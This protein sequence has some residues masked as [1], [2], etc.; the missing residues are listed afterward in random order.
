MATEQEALAYMDE[1][2]ESLK[3]DIIDYQDQGENWEV[4]RDQSEILSAGTL[5]ENSPLRSP[6]AGGGN[7]SDVEEF[8]L[9]EGLYELEKDFELQV[10]VP[11]LDEALGRLRENLASSV[12]EWKDDLDMVTAG[13]SDSL[14]TLDQQDIKYRMVNGNAVYST[15]DSFIE[16]MAHQYAEDYMARWLETNSSY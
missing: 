6:I 9:D 3:Q 2:I 8:F 14:V 7:N 12:S 1:Q 10:D 4:F 15:Y 16:D 5:G 13:I 11:A